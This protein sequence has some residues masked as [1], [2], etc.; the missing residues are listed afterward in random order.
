MLKTVLR[1]NSSAEG[2]GT[3]ISNFSSIPESGENLRQCQEFHQM[4]IYDVVFNFPVFTR[5]EIF[6]LLEK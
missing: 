6:S 2:L 5:F 4:S 3:M 1:E